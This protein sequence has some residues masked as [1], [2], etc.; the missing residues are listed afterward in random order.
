MKIQAEILTGDGR[1]VYNSIEEPER[2]APCAR[3]FHG[4][5]ILLPALSFAVLRVGNDC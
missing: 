3:A 4:P 2:V 1:D 5:D